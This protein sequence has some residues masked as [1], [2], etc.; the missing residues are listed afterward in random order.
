MTTT[1]YA[2]TVLQEKKDTQSIQ[3]KDESFAYEAAQ[4][5]SGSFTGPLYEALWVNFYDMDA[6]TQHLENLFDSGNH[7]GLVYFTFI[8]ANAVNLIIPIQFT[9][10]SANDS[11][12]PV[13]SAAI[14]EDWLE[15]DVNFEATRY[16]EMA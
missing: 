9:E 14:I 2:Q 13:L 11:L 3:T 7:F 1:E 10:M 15:Y 12:V 5:I 4:L 16:N 6:V 8:L